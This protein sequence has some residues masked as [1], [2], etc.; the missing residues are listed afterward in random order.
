MITR[1]SKIARLPKPIRDELNHRLEGG[2]IGRTILPWLNALP[3]T[4][5]IMA[6]F[7]GGNSVTHQNLSEWRHGGY[8]DW[9]QHQHR[10]E[11]YDRFSENETE[12]AEHDGCGDTFDAMSRLF[13]AGIGQNLAAIENLKI[14]QE[15]FLRMENLTREFTRL[16]NAYNYSRR[17]QLDFDKYNAQFEPEPEPLGAPCCPPEPSSRLTAPTTSVSL[18]PIGGEG[19]GEGQACKPTTRHLVNLKT[20]AS[21]L[22]CAGPPAL[23]RALRKHLSTHLP[24]IA[25]SPRPPSPSPPSGGRGPGV[26]LFTNP[27][28][29]TV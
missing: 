25:P 5:T 3:E 22:E 4:K 2:Q 17:V 8:Q 21:V 18:T 23:C 13:L 9:L 26:S 20:R 19:R 11:W 7:F 16:Q 1:I 15:R 6:E 12:L 29:D 10:L 28:P 24:K 14:P 27:R